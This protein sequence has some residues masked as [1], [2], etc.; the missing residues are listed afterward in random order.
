MNVKING[1][2]ARKTWGIVFDSTSISA[3]MTPAPMKDYIENSSRLEHG[4]H[5]LTNDT[6][7]DARSITLS[8][9]LIARNETEFFS[10]YNAFCNELEKGTIIIELSIMNGVI[11][12]CIY[13]SCSQFTQYNNKLARFSLKI[14]E[15]NPKDRVKQV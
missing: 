3:L 7:V 1:Y 5:V 9:S 15:P 6:K 2:D 14:E 4:K 10:R 13:K 12:K 11:F 8:F